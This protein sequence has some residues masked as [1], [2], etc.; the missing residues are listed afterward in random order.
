MHLH[1]TVVSKL[2]LNYKLNKRTRT[3]KLGET[4]ART[5]RHIYVRVHLCVRTCCTYKRKHTVRLFR[6][7]TSKYT[8]KRISRPKC[9]RRGRDGVK[10]LV[11]V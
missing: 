2:I 11:L 4:F 6:S 10:M 7:Y 9:L 1:Y 3:D 5:S 8:H